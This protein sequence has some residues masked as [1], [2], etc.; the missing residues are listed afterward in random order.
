MTVAAGTSHHIT[1][2]QNDALYGFMLRDPGAYQ[3]QRADDFA[4]R[5]S[6]G[7]DPSLREGIWDAWAQ[8]GFPEGIDQPTVRNLNKILSSDGNIFGGR[9]ESITLDSAWNSS[10]AS[11]VSTAPM[12]VDFPG[13]TNYVCVGF[14]ASGTA[15]RIRRYNLGAGTWSTATTTF[16]S[17]VVWL[18]RHGGYMF[19]ACGSGDSIQRSADLDTWTEPAAQTANCICT[20]QSGT[21]TYLVL[22]VDATIKL[23]SDN[24]A[25]W[26][27]A[28]TCDDA[29]VN[30]TG[31]GVAFG[32]LVIG[33]EDAI[34]TYDGT[35]VTT[36]M[37]FPEKR[38]SGNCRAL[39][40]HQGFLWT[41][42]LGEIIKI[43]FSAGGIS[44]T[45]NVT[46]VKYGD[47]NE[48][49]YG[50]GIPVWIW[51]GPFNLYVAFDDGASVYPEVLMH[52]GLG[53][54]QAYKG[55]SGD[56]MYAAG[57]SRLGSMTFINDGAT[58]LRRHAN[59]RDLPYP[60]YPST[61]VF[62]TSDFDAGLPFMYK[63][64]REIAIEAENIT[65]GAGSIAV[66]YSLDKGANFVTLGTIT[67]SG[68]TYMQFPGGTAVSSQQ[69]RLRFTFTRNS[70]S[71][72]PRMRRFA[73]WV[74][75]RPTP[76]YV[77]HVDLK[78]F[79]NQT[80]MD[81]TSESVSTD[82]RLA[83]LLGA[84]ASKTPVVFSDWHGRSYDVYITK[85]S[86]SHLKPRSETDPPEEIWMGVDMII[87]LQ[88]G[89]WDEI[90][91]NAANW[92]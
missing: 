58:R 43:S 82:E 35:T 34:C 4:P 20:W 2:E 39:V 48:E 85:T 42:I 3:V 67:T 71:S 29:N 27:S 78:L 14:D 40:Y 1:L 36:E 64:Y 86:R 90:Y 59:I 88:G 41:H 62:T 57:Y 79:H 17:D 73:L 28:I 18:H 69:L 33:K 61:G 13:G 10:D 5:I 53:W 83:F 56:T 31:L 9:G 46:P 12:I 24:G 38:Y 72:T 22:A 8:S 19:A 84:E 91:W 74:L 45:A 37:K 44:N 65:T 49:L 77:F 32:L 11:K 55:A 75:T 52:N 63:A 70:S 21:T 68:K 47:E 23:S 16:A 92:S 60:D 50:H 6:V 54:H 7:T 30:I 51:S 25:T 66:A 87:V 89:R 15:A 76:I 81:D 80:L 26:G